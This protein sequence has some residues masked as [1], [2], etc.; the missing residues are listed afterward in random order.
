MSEITDKVLV[1]TIR[2]LLRLI[3]N[4][5]TSLTATQLALEESGTLQDA[6]VERHRLRLEAQS[7]D[8]LRKLEEAP[9][10]TML[11]ILKRFEGPPQ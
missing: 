9:P 11:E 4:L 7:Q 10:D 1:S 2:Q 6:A 8:V 5:Q 3:V